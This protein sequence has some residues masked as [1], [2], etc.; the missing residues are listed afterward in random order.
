MQPDK[1]TTLTQQAFQA[2]QSD[3]NERGHSELT[4]EHLLRA[5]LD[6]ADGVTRP[7]LEKVGVST[8]KLGEQLDAELT[9]RPKIVSGSG[10]LQ[11][12]R[13]LRQTLDAA[14]REMKGL[15]D[16]FLSAEHYLLAL[17]CGTDPAARLL[18]DL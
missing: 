13:T 2:A 3:A 10:Q 5:F 1:F 18:K 7:L 11:L 12:S 14:D 4:N 8:P 16:E 17:T 9:R 6:Q 15:K